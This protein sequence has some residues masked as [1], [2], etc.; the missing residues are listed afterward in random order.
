MSTDGLSR[1]RFFGLAGAGT[2]GVVAAGTAGGAIGPATAGEPAGVTG[3]DDWWGR[4]LL[5]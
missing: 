4:A 5:S 2:V 3:P 1:R